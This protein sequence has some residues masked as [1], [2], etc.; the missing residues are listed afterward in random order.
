MA[1]DTRH[2][3]NT[4]NTAAQLP[5][6]IL[7]MIPSFISTSRDLFS[8]SQVCRRWRTILVSSPLLW[9]WIDCQ[10]FTHTIVSLKRHRAV[11]LRLELHGCLSAKALNAVL[12]HGSKIYSVSAH[13]PLDQL[14]QVHHRLVIPSVEDIV[15]FVDEDPKDSERV[16]TVEIQAGSMSLRRLLVSGIFVP[17]SQITAPN[18][19]H[20]SL[21]KM[22]YSSS[23][24]TEQSIWN[25]LQRCSQ[26]E[27][28]L[29]NIISSCSDPLQTYTP[30]ALPKLRSIELGYG[31]VEAGLVLPLR[32][33][34]TVA[35]GFRGISAEREFWPC[36]STQH[37][38]STID[39][40]SVT[41]AHIRHS[42]DLRYWDGD[43]YLI[44]FEG[45]EGSLEITFVEKP[46]RN[47]FGPDGLL[48]SLS[49][50]F[51]N[52]KT[53]FVVDCRTCDDTLTAMGSVMHNLV[54]INF[55]RCNTYLNSLT[56]TGSSPPLF[57]HLKH[58]AGPPLER[59][60]VEMARARDERGMPLVTMDLHEYPWCANVTE[61]MIELREFVEDA[62]FR[63]YADPPE[64]WASNA[65][66]DAWEAAG[67]TGPVSVWS[68]GEIRADR[69]DCI[70][71]RHLVGYW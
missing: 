67:Y 3:S 48:L 53:L 25:M 19:T 68:A 8:V 50:Q 40:E 12:N 43:T 42:K 69:T 60:L 66:L 11:P 44:R 6:D 2:P 61:Y 10:K 18:L 71:R 56:P 59:K 20:L 54:S 65:L 26:L 24:I 51:N 33:P 5:S 27:T 70:P 45:F 62:K 9:R 52:V 57:P 32:F 21:E 46:G 30:F 31:E 7:F 49:S 4:F 17:P 29:I 22:I 23:E 64:R 35:V 28:I 39:I 55:T 37:V 58:I 1:T 16:A 13:I 34:P 63:L 47:P 15:L 14:R 38:L 36:E 41:L